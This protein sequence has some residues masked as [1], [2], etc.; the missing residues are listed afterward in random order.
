MREEDKISQLREITSELVG[1]IEVYRSL[2]EDLKGGFEDGSKLISN[3]LEVREKIKKFMGR[4][5]KNFE[6][7]EASCLAPGYAN[8]WGYFLNII[9]EAVDSFRKFKDNDD[10]TD[11][12]KREKLNDKILNSLPDSLKRQLINSRRL[13][14]SF[15]LYF[16]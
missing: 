1:E 11:G 5:F 15:I 8:P 3:Y 7:Y 4:D 14:R 10:L 2:K 12:L 16:R 13:L 6:L 9:P